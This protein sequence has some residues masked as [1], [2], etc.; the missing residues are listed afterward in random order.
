MKKNID[1]IAF[2][3]EYGAYQEIACIKHFP[4]HKR[5]SCK[6]FEDVFYNVK[7][8]LV[9]IGIVPIEN[10]YVGRVSEIHNLLKTTNLY[11]TGEYQI[12]INH[13]LATLPNSKF[14]DIDKVISHPMALM[15]CKQN[16]NKYNFQTESEVNTATAAKNLSKNQKKNIA[17]ICSE[18][19]CK[20]YDLKI[21]DN[22]FQDV[23]ENYTLFITIEKN[24]LVKD[25]NQPAITTILF[26]LNNK[27]AALYEILGIFA[28][29]KFNI[30]KIESYIPCGKSSNAEFLL[31]FQADHNKQ[32]Y[33]NALEQIQKNCYK[34]KILG[35]YPASN[36]HLKK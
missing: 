9:H 32:Q 3:G 33:Q 29:N 10:S 18:N 28:Q 2:Q 26:Q 16:I 20:L 35:F 15:Q 36:Y 31:S 23:D 27:P 8:D 19:A 25:F 6:T 24:L 11:I 21:I 1:S 30:T 17:V 22:H 34:S 7:N 12:K 14:E 4:D 5:I 13:C